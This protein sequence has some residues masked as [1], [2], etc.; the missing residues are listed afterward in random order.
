MAILDGGMLDRLID[1]EERVAALEGKPCEEVVEESSVDWRD[2]LSKG[3]PRWCVVWDGGWRQELQPTVL[4]VV[5]YVEEASYP[6]TTIGGDGDYEHAYPLPDD[7]A[8]R[9]SM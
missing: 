2:S 4:L 9:S 6:Y 5:D 3:S 1:L 7:M 8:G